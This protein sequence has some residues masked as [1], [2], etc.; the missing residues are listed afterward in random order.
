MWFDQ[1]NTSAL[2]FSART[3]TVSDVEI[4]LRQMTAADI[5]AAL[6]IERDVYGD[7]PWDRFV[8]LS[9]LQKVHSRLYVVAVNMAGRVV[10]FIGASFHGADSHIT[11][12]AVASDCQRHGLGKAMLQAMMAVA[13]KRHA[14][15]MT[16]EVRT[17][18]ANAQQL[19]RSLGFRDGRIKRN[20]YASTHQDALDMQLDLSP[21]CAEMEQGKV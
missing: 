17:D 19:Y 11:N 21:A 2:A 1:L 6:D 9:E 15:R 20:Y 16:L 5:G 7:T 10:A 8:F 18:N 4:I 3:I 14:A 13:E 12:L